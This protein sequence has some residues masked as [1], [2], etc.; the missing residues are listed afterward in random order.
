MQGSNNLSLRYD[1]WVNGTSWRPRQ[2]FFAALPRVDVATMTPAPADPSSATQRFALL[3]F[4]V[5][6]LFRQPNSSQVPTVHQILVHGSQATY[7]TCDFSDVDVVVV[8]DDARPFSIPQHRG[9][10]VALQLLLRD[11]YAYDPLMHHGLMFIGKQTL[12][13]YEESFLP[14]ETL[15]LA[16]VAYGQ[17]TMELTRKTS[18]ASDA[19]RRLQNAAANL[20]V[21]IATGS[22][23]KGDYQLK[24]FLSGILLLPALFLAT[25]G[26][27]VY[28][29]ESFA[30]VNPEF[31]AQ[32]WEFIWQAE[33]TR[34][35]WRRPPRSP[36]TR[37]L[38]KLGHP[39]LEILLADR[40]SPRLNIRNRQIRSNL[41]K[42]LRSAEPFFGK[43]GELCR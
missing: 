38:S 4:S 11:I 17:K 5:G 43:L 2:L 25:R 30:L 29:R 34:L 15:K 31:Q 12:L 7:D 27:Y 32:E 39:R 1:Y 24:T 16:K 26:R 28:K 14:L 40:F 19:L 21:Q 42:L 3:P 36:A 33:L 35:L 10:I 13:A 20:K 37:A 6:H 9:S 41:D 8:L 23:L 18:A 22:Y